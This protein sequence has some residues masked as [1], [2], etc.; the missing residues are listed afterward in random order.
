MQRSVRCIAGRPWQPTRA[1]KC[2]LWKQVNHRKCNFDFKC[3]NKLNTLWLSQSRKAW[4]SWMWFIFHMPF[5]EILF[6]IS[7]KCGNTVQKGR[8]LWFSSDET[9]FHLWENVIRKQQNKLLWYSLNYGIKLLKSCDFEHCNQHAI[10]ELLQVIL[11][12]LSSTYGVNTLSEY[13]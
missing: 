11:R 5:W 3:H 6:S 13:V 9:C 7:K 4:W 2:C 1:A 8:V 12:V 10:Q